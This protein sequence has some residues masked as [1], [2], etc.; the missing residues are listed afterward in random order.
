MVIDFEGL[1]AFL[2]EDMSDTITLGQEFYFY[3]SSDHT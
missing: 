1:S 3:C 2:L